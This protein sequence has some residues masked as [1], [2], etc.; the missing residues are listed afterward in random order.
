MANMGRIAALALA[1][2]LFAC[3]TP[4][5][6]LQHA[7][8]AD[9]GAADGSGD[10]GSTAKKSLALK[11]I[12]P[13]RSPL[14]GGIDLDLAGDGFAASTK[15]WIG[16]T[17][18]TVQYVAGTTHLFVTAPPATVPGQVDVRVQNGTGAPVVLA[19]GLTYLGKV[20]VDSFDPLQGP[21]VGGTEI[22]VRGSGFLPGDRVLVGYA[23]ALSSQ[24]VDSTTIVAV[25]PPLP[26]A[27][28][29]DAPDLVKSIVAV[30]HGSGLTQATAPFTYGRVPQ[31]DF[32][33]PAVVGLDGGAVTLHGSALGNA[34]ALY[35][36]GALSDLA[37]GTAG[38]VRGATVPAL[39]A[40]D[41]TAQPGPADLLWTSPFGNGKL[42][43][44]F[45]YADPAG[46]LALYGAVPAVGS[47]SGG[48]PVTL[49][50]SLP[51]GTPL[52]GVEFAGISIQSVNDNGQFVVS[53]P[54][55][56][57]GSVDIAITAG[58]NTV[59][60]ANAFRYFDPVSLTKLSSD[61]GPTNGG[62]AIT[63]TGKGLST[64]CNVR[65]GTY[66]AEIKSASADGKTL[67]ILTP[68]GAP[69]TADVTVTCGTSTAILSQG[70]A[71]TDKLHINAVVPASGATGGG[72]LVTLYGSGFKKGLQVAF[73]GKSASAISVSDSSHA[74]VKTP[75]HAAGPVAVSVTFGKDSDTLIDGYSYFSPS[76][77]NGGTWGS[78]LGGTLN[79]TVLNIY[80]QAPIED[81]FVQLGQPGDSLYNTYG[82]QTDKTG[83]IVFS[84][85]DIIGNI[86]VSASKTGFSASS[87]VSFDAGN[88][89]LLL[90]PH[91]PPS[92]GGGGGPTQ[93]TTLANLQGTVLDIDKYLQVPPTNCLKSGDLGDKTCNTCATD[94]D[95]AGTSASGATF[96]CVDNGVAGKRC[97]GHCQSANDC[98]KGFGC[99]SDINQPGAMF[100]KPSIGIRKVFCATS[101]RDIDTPNPAPSNPPDP[102]PSVPPVKPGHLSTAPGYA[103]SEVDELT[104]TFE[105][106]SR[107]DELAIQCVGGYVANDTGLFVPTVLGIRRH[108]FPMASA[109]LA[110]QDVR[111]DIP[112]GR[113]LAVRL[114]HP[115]KY[116][117]SNL[118]GTL[119]V[120]AWLNLGSDG[121]VVLEDFMSQGGMAGVTGVMD[122]V[123]LLHQPTD[124]PKEL[125][126]TTYTYFARAEFGGTGSVPITATLHEDVVDPG[127]TNLRIRKADGTTADSAL[128]ID[129]ELSAVLAG[130]DG[131]VLIVALN[132]RA[133]RGTPDDPK[134]VYLPPVLDPYAQPAQVLAAAGTP[135]DAIMVGEAG[136]IRR[137]KG[138]AVQQEQGALAVTLRAACQGPLGR[139]AVGDGGGIEAYRTTVWEKVAAP[140][141][142]GPTLRAVLCTDTG[143]IAVGD[144]GQIV[145]IDLTGSAPIASASTNATVD[146][147]T[148]AADSSGTLWVGGNAPSGNGPLLLKRI[149]TASWETGW[150]AGTVTPSYKPLRHIVALPTG[151]LLLIDR[152]G[153]LH[154]M[155]AAGIADESP[156]RLDLRPRASAVLPD[157]SAVLVGQPGLWLGPFLTIP[158]IDKPGM[159]LNP[160]PMVVEWSVAPGPQPSAT[161]V[162]LDGNQ[163]PFWWLYVAP[164]VTSL[165]LPDFASLKGIQVFPAGQQISYVATVNRIYIPGLS[166]NGFATMD[167]EFGSRRSWA[168]NAAQFVK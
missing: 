92:Q 29:P 44:A 153:G 132:G 124:L 43:P 54:A 157:G 104:G 23:E 80:T 115:Q 155:D 86:T 65:I 50:L 33:T 130:A 31:I 112:L 24:V 45:A 99:F 117:P 98:G 121:Y 84:G 119:R 118:G 81:A 158:S 46:G 19:K 61:N 140:T 93:A 68:P 114:D 133:Y 136:L 56:K 2:A 123:D 135:T 159:G 34:T 143:A 30:R 12:T 49:L 35:A 55:H 100:C 7:G 51:P 78:S 25:V 71:F 69:G 148:I 88:A 146:F 22:T 8:S 72:S 77:S 38:G 103:S 6:P 109:T 10:G 151:A 27:T 101:L 97:L 63:L 20:T 129:L 18:A 125:T 122:D 59:K 9:A 67:A 79:V 37:A 73:D 17:E 70:F 41:P 26:G 166:I 13:S 106:S 1:L 15:V 74:T 142:T 90:W 57:A 53:A 36:H 126:D 94:K 161:L 62:A 85:P 164:D 165:Q 96:A 58:G 16:A 113:T 95:C 167:V 4:Q 162:H 21:E 156:E 147:Y 163:F 127:D 76:N 137:L 83:Q 42:S 87:I 75:P 14:A 145:E 47:S 116:F 110:G 60:L 5:Y 28:A 89:T 91:V 105:I 52:D 66:P 40:L 134:L 154:R 128:G 149:G 11:M 3:S 107:L 108:V 138:N 141:A 64:N 139:V 144:A 82:G 160:V 120:G 152:E 111:L 102:P 131:Q 48:E 168:T 32:V 150:P 39:H